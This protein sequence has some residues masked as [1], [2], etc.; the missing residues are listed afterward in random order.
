MVGRRNQRHYSRWPKAF[1]WLS[2]LALVAA[3]LLMA[4]LAPPIAGSG[5]A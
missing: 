3:A 1:A 2:V 4:G 5:S